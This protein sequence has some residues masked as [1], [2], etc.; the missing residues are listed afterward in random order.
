[1]ENQTHQNQDQKFQ[2]GNQVSV[3]ELYDDSGS[4]DSEIEERDDPAEDQ[5]GK[6]HSGL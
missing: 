3:D 6:Y 5:F 2:D 1:M 4:E